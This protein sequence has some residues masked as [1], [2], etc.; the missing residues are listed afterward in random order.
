MFLLRL[1]VVVYVNVTVD[2]NTSLS[3]N[4]IIV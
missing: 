3:P 4:V 1:C 2:V